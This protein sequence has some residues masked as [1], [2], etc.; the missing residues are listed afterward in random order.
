MHCILGLFVQH[1]HHF[2]ADLLI[3]V[4]LNASKEALALLS[5]GAKTENLSVML[6]TVRSIVSA[7]IT[8]DHKCFNRNIFDI[9]Q[10]GVFL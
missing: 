2:Y 1:P 4:T 10:G 6:K 7:V 9:F 8:K 3:N 5:L